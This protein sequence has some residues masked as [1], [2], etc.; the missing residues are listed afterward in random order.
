VCS[1][2]TQGWR[3]RIAGAE[4]KLSKGASTGA[5]EIG[6][7]TRNVG[8][9]A[10]D[11]C[12]SDRSGGDGLLR[13]RME[14]LHLDPNELAQSDSLMFGDLR[15]L[16]MMCKSRGACAL[17]LA[18]GSADPAWGEWREYCPNAATLNEL[19]IRSKVRVDPISL[20]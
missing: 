15:R 18:R 11:F 2:I 4:S 5:G 19:R 10:S 6:P 8:L 17:E 14:T 20:R 7:A 3:T 1:A 13:R 12:A 9:C 16:C